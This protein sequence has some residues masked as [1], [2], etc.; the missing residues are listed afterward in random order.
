MH[1]SGIIGY[2][3]W[4]VIILISYYMIR[5]ALKRFDKKVAEEAEK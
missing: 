5:W 2:L 3:L 4:P 1:L